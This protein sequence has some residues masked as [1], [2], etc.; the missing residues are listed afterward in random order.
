MK[1]IA[2]S[3]FAAALA[4][5]SAP[6]LAADLSTP[7]PAVVAP[8]AAAPILNSIGIEVSP[9]FYLSPA[10]VP[11][12]ID[13][14]YIKGSYSR[15]LPGGFSWGASIQ[16]TE[17]TSSG[18]TNR[19]QLQPETTL[20]YTIKLGPTF[21][22]PL[23]AGVGLLY[24]NVGYAPVTTSAGSFGYYVFNAGLNVK[25]DSHWTWNAISARYRNAFAGK[26]VTPK[27]GTGV[28]YTIDPH[29]SVYVNGGYAWQTQNV[30]GYPLEPNK[31]NIALGYKYG[32]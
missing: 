32:F 10:G 4:G 18:S 14:G 30:A 20:G 5:I 19:Y 27:L 8:A 6:T 22:I 1:I 29:N 11:G 31:W 9:E 2:R 17:R 26:W 24:N 7:A 3:L 15:S 23:S 16:Y 13:D 21:S 12:A 28:T 25:L